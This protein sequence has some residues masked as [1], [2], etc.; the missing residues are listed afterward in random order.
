MADAGCKFGLLFGKRNTSRAG[1]SLKISK[2]CFLGAE[3]VT[4]ELIVTS[5][6]IGF[7]PLTTRAHG[8]GWSLAQEVL[9]SPLL[10]ILPPRQKWRGNITME[11]ALAL[12]CTLELH[13]RCTAHIRVALFRVL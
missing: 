5:D 8:N 6:P 13:C 10:S 3:E 4:K 11:Q 2:G 7:N 9:P 1:K 12:H